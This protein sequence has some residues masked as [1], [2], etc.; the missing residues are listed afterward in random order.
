MDHST[1]AIFILFFDLFVFDWFE[2]KH[3][4][5]ELLLVWKLILIWDKNRLAVFGWL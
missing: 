5:T 1:S 3:R 2:Y 4:W